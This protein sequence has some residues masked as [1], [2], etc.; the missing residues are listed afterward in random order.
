M[1]LKIEAILFHLPDSNNLMPGLK[2]DPD[3]IEM[4]DFALDFRLRVLKQAART[5]MICFGEKFHPKVHS[6]ISKYVSDGLIPQEY[7]K[8]RAR[9]MGEVEGLMV[10][11]S[12]NFFITGQ[13]KIVFLTKILETK[14]FIAQD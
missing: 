3:Y 11:I 1:N 12:E 8:L 5:R 7:V 2:V 13:L 6:L 14:N 9:F 10:K 4:L